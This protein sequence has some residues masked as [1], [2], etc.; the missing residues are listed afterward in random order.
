MYF[1][2]LF[3]SLF[4]LY[5]ELLLFLAQPVTPVWPVLLCLLP[6]A[7]AAG[8]LSSAILSLFRNPK[9]RF[10][11]SCAL[12][13]LFPVLFL[14]DHRTFCFLYWWLYSLLGSCKCRKI[15]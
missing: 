9:L 8:L 15:S 5:E 13:A 7:A 12:L 10:G 6:A 11:L 14:A 2:V 1:T 3:F 4:F